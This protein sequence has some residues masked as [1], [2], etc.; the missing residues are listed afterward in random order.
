MRCVCVKT[1]LCVLA[2]VIVTLSS[3]LARDVAQVN[4]AV[5]KRPAVEVY[6]CTVETYR[7]WTK[8]P[9][10]PRDYKPHHFSVHVEV[11]LP[12]FGVAYLPAYG[13][14]V[15]ADRKRY[16]EPTSEIVGRGRRTVRANRVPQ[17][18]LT[19]EALQDVLQKHKA[20]LKNRSTPNQSAPGDDK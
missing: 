9:R 12:E 15:A 16:S 3:C 18:T 4:P 8:R 17:L 10:A 13:S 20:Y 14:F 11:Y 6:C 19:R 2:C 1:A 7:P 5:P